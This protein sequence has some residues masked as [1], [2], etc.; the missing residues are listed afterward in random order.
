MHG[1]INIFASA[2]KNTYEKLLDETR[3]SITIFCTVTVSGVTGPNIFLM[4]VE[5]QKKAF[6]DY[7]LIR[8]GLAPGSTVT[9]TENA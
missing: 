9:M 2:Y 7:Y 6:T 3:V 4:K 5:K 1:D 8:N